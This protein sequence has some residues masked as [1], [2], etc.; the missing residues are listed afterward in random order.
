M[1][2][3]PLPSPPKSREPSPVRSASPPP[4]TASS[5]LPS[6]FSSSPTPSSPRTSCSAG[7]CSR[8]SPELETDD[9]GDA[10][11]EL[12]HVHVGTLQLRQRWVDREVSKSLTAAVL[13]GVV[14]VSFLVGI[15]AT[16]AWDGALGWDRCALLCG[17]PA[18][19]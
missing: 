2:P 14:L 12:F 11:K 17:I 18:Q 8:P 5:Y 9:N 10:D 6:I 1:D 15:L 4:S 13:C 16:R 7:R 19:P 3:Q